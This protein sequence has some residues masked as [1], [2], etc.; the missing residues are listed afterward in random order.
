MHRKH[1]KNIEKKYEYYGIL[2]IEKDKTYIKV[3]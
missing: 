2:S 3:K 1:N